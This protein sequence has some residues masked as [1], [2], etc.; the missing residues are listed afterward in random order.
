MRTFLYM[1]HSSFVSVKSSHDYQKE[2]KDENETEGRGSDS[3]FLPEE[4]RLEAK[5]IL[6]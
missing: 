5:T 6:S 2:M 3:F 4:K 1:D